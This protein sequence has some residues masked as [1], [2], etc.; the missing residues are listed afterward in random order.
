MH[1]LEDPDIVETP[2]P[3]AGADVA[4]PVDVVVPVV[5]AAKPVEVETT[6]D[7]FEVVSTSAWNP[8]DPIDDATLSA[9]TA[10]EVKA[11]DPR[12]RL[13]IAGLLKRDRERA[14][15]LDT[16]KATLA[17]SKA[18]QDAA[19]AAT[20]RDIE[21]KRLAYSAAVADPKVIDKL[22]ADMAAKPPVLNP[23]D[24]ANVE[25]WMDAKAAEKQ[26][27]AMGP[28]AAEYDQLSRNASAD[29]VFEAV[30]LNRKDDADK[31]AVNVKLRELYGRPD[32]SD[33]AFGKHIVEMRIQAQRNGG[34]A[35]VEVAASLVA[36]ERKAAAN[37]A[38]RADESAAR[39]AGARQLSTPT[40]RVTRAATDAEYVD[41]KIK[42]IGTDPEAF[43]A[44]WNADP[45]FRAAM[46]AVQA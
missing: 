14:A 16:E 25:A 15:A 34:R 32:M 37:G 31:A 13:V 27:A 2:K 30:G 8:D 40:A 12:S 39:L 4:A 45:K 26:L 29:A 36:A 23:A 46:S 9:I 24:P 22:R 11:M 18:A 7:F 44:L 33:E 20:L 1:L 38:R 6:P 41:A 28:A 17:E 21:R 35:P 19:N 10:D 43:D 3:E 42:E 5:D